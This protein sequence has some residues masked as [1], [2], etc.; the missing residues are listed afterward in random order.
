MKRELARVKHQSFGLMLGYSVVFAVL[1]PPHLALRNPALSGA[2]KLAAGLLFVHLVLRLVQSKRAVSPVFLALVAL[3][4]S[5]LPGTIAHNGDLLTWGFES[6]RLIA[7]LVLLEH[8]LGKGRVHAM[9]VLKGLA[10]LLLLYLFLNLAM[11][12]G[13]SGLST[14]W[15][16][17]EFEQTVYFLGIRTRITDVIFPAI[18]AAVLVDVL[19]CSRWQLRSLFAI[20]LGISQIAILDVATGYVGLVVLAAVYVTVRFIP[21]GVSLFSWRNISILGIIAF[22]GIVIFRAHDSFEFLISEWLGKS[23]ELTGRTVI[24]DNAIPILLA[25]PIVGYGVNDAFGAFVPWYG[26][27][28][29]QAHNQYLQLMHDGGFVGIALFI[30]L[31][32][33]AG[34]QVDR[35]AIGLREKAALAAVYCAMTLMSITE[36]FV[37]NMGMFYL[38]LFLGGCARLF[39][40][41]EE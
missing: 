4:A 15:G 26:S 30:L 31:L 33:V 6:V 2:L 36:I 14:S 34:R 20:A 13:G 17:G 1:L 40:L 19:D 35:A 18:L 12:L 10:N 5:L 27:I 38:V 24:W 8:G 32:L 37:Y 22:L 16:P 21:G 9:V 28:L 23:M 25:A 39:E 3:R 7:L 11:V 29:W 41:G